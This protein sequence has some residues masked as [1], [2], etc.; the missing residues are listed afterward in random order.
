MVSFVKVVACLLVWPAS[1]LA[2]PNAPKVKHALF[3]D[4]TQNAAVAPTDTRRGFVATGIASVVAL[5][6][7]A[8]TPAFADIPMI[9]TEEFG[10]ILRDSAQAV[11]VVEFSG[12]KSE[13]VTVRLFDGTSF[14]LKDVLES[15]VDPRSPLKIA[16]MCRESRVNTKFLA[17]EAALQNAPKRKVMYTN[18]R[19][20]VAAEKEKAKAA[21]IQQDEEARLAELYRM[22][23]EAA[24]KGASAL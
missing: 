1:S 24:A 17:L 3:S 4:Q 7:I 15:P 13:T 20:R 2:P 11:Q 14:G 19:V 18:E 23:E 22:Q 8:P 10:I 12:P 16:A 9:T 6:A 21:R 5:M